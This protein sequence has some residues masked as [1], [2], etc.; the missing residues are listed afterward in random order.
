MSDMKNSIILGLIFLLLAF[1]SFA[2]PLQ[3]SGGAG[4]AILGT[5]DLN[6]S[7]NATNSTNETE[8]WSWG[9]LP[10]GHFINA[11]GKLAANP[12]NDDGLVIVQPRSDG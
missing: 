8:I 1:S 2:A 12:I 6:N 10:V 5:I 11:S 4:R 3:L 7:T 9:K